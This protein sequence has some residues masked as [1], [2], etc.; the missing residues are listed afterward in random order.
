MTLLRNPFA[1]RTPTGTRAEVT[2]YNLKAAESFLFGALVKLTSGEIEEC[3]ADPAY[4]KGVAC[5][6]AA[7]TLEAGYIN[8]YDADRNTI[9]E[10]CSTVA[11]VRLTHVGNSYGVV[12]TSNVW[13]LDT[14]ETGTKVFEVVDVDTTKGVYYCKFTQ[15]AIDA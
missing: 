8:V 2:R 3:A 13:L 9:W 12:K 15:A 11:P 1:A 14:T 6:G 5:D 4:V 7:D 10:V